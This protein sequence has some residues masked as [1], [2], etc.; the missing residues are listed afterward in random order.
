MLPSEKSE[1][2]AWRLVLTVFVLMALFILVWLVGFISR[3]FRQA[4]Q[5]REIPA[6]TDAPLAENG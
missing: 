5:Q 4:V 6:D 3:V 2:W 1:R